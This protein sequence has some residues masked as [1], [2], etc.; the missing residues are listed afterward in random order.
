MCDFSVI[1]NN[2]FARPSKRKFQNFKLFAIAKNQSSCAFRCSRSQNVW[3][4]VI[5][6]TQ[7]SIFARPC[8]VLQMKFFR[9]SDRIILAYWIMK[10]FWRIDRK[11]IRNVG[12]KIL[13]NIFLSLTKNQGVSFPKEKRYNFL[14]QITNYTI[15]FLN[16][17]LFYQFFKRN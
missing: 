8:C 5:T 1:T 14:S 10:I 9:D 13:K 17:L 3:F 7:F 12:N 15:F 6:S 11:S 16:R 2:S 4:S